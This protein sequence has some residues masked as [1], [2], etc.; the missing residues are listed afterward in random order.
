M[1]VSK[2]FVDVPVDPSLDLK[3]EIERLK[4]E[5]KAVVMAH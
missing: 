1:N 2:G 4:K 5:K 3:K